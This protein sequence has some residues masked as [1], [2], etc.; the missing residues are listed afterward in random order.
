MARQNNVRGEPLVC[1]LDLKLWLPVSFR[2]RAALRARSTGGYDS[3]KKKKPA[4][5]TPPDYVAA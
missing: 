2:S 5:D 3:R 1:N 4:S